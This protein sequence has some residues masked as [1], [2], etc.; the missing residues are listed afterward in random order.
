MK[1]LAKVLSLALVLVMVL[2]LGGTA[3]ADP[4]QNPAL[5]STVNDY[6][7]P[8]ENDE[9]A[10]AEN[11]GKGSIVVENAIEG[12]DYT[13][14][15]LFDVEY[16]DEKDAWVYTIDKDDSSISFYTAIDTG[17]LCSY[18]SLSPV[19]G[20]ETKFYVVPAE[21]P[22]GLSDTNAADF[23][24]EL[25]TAI[26]KGDIRFG[27]SYSIEK[28]GSIEASPEDINTR[29]IEKIP[30]GYY[31]ITTTAGTLCSLDTT[32][33]EAHVIEKNEEP[34]INKTVQEDS[35]VA[36]AK[37]EHASDSAKP[38][39]DDGDGRTAYQKQNDVEIGQKVY[40][41]TVINVKPGATNYVLYDKMSEGLKFIPTS[42]KIYLVADDDELVPNG[43]TPIATTESYTGTNLVIDD[44]APS[45]PKTIVTYA[46]DVDDAYH[47]SATAA[48]EKATFTLSFGNE[49][50]D[51][52]DDKESQPQQIIVTY[53]ALLTDAAV[54]ARPELNDTIMTYGNNNYTQEEE[55]KT[56]TWGIKV[57]KYTESNQDAVYAAKDTYTGADA[58][59]AAA[60]EGFKQN[61]SS[62]EDSKYWVK[63]TQKPL[64][65]AKF[66]LY[67]QDDS[68][69]I[70]FVKLDDGIP[71]HYQ[72]VYQ[73]YDPDNPDVTPWKPAAQNPETARPYTVDDLKKMT[74]S[75][76]E[77]AAEE[78][79]VKVLE[80][81]D[82][83]MIYIGG[84]D[85]YD[86]FYYL[87]EVEAPE[88]YNKLS[89]PVEVTLNSESDDDTKP[90]T[91][92]QNITAV[93]SANGYVLAG[94]ENNT[95]HELPSTGGV[96]TTLFYVFGSMLVIAA[97]V[98]F[99]TK[100]RS[101]VE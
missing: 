72:V 15:K 46:V 73:D 21:A 76:I 41:K 51:Q 17:S 85:E 100:K 36:R 95:G 77:S 26:T 9:A 40:Y 87:L 5:N 84:L 16:T 38:D 47:S 83:G 54:V 18:F 98:Y 62:N 74:E 94:V 25:R 33:H 34:S 53:E 59:E 2:S 92:T 44:Q 24:K 30:L 14:Y 69:N 28:E 13:A 101:E 89:Q 82:N 22:N 99:V 67:R 23:A 63:Y 65:G 27:T 49:W 68:G 32:A 97:A 39:G 88:G 52:V 91:L 56:F 57:F 70:Y 1:K 43:A 55:T 10:S 29:Y 78:M 75:Q 71:G 58:A 7:S 20:S 3:W 6:K 79:T 66:V 8:G 61:T 37:A 90:K 48:P 4:T 50:L 11:I 86:Q 81:D 96:G 93:D 12:K 64:A 45:N 35:L 60:A 19:P 42:V 31:F 80:S